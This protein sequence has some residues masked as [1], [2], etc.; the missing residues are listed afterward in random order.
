MPRKVKKSPLAKALD[1]IWRSE[2]VAHPEHVARWRVGSPDMEQLV[3]LKPGEI[4]DG[5]KGKKAPQPKRF[6]VEWPK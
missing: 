6:K 4:I 5:G 3:G 2:A 1:K